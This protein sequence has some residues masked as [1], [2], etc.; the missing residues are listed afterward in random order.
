VQVP[1]GL[2]VLNLADQILAHGNQGSAEVSV[3]RGDH[4]RGPAWQ[5]H[6]KRY[7]LLGA[8]AVLHRDLNINLRSPPMGEVPVQRGQDFQE[9]AAI[10]GAEAD[11]ETQPLGQDGRVIHGQ[12]STSIGGVA[13]CSGGLPSALIPEGDLDRAF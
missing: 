7:L 5:P 2:V 4:E 8:A 6:L 12:L 10:I 13:A 1:P 11:T 3:G 9:M